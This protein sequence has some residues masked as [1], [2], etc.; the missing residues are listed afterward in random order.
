VFRFFQF[1]FQKYLGLLQ[2]SF[3]RPAAYI[4]RTRIPA[5][6]FSRC[7]RA[8]ESHAEIVAIKKAGEK[9]KGAT[10][11]NNKFVVSHRCAYPNAFIALSQVAKLIIEFAFVYMAVFAVITLDSYLLARPTRE[12]PTR[13]GGLFTSDRGGATKTNPLTRGQGRDGED[14]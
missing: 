3:V 6:P 1:F 11:M 8:G 14:L 5:W 10:G 9:A 4:P 12:D 2:V 7:A 13:D